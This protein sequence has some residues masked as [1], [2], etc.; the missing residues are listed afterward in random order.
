MPNQSLERVH[1]REFG[2]SMIV[3]TCVSEENLSNSLRNDIVDFHG[4]RDFP[5]IHN[6]P[7]L[8]IHLE[9]RAFLGGVQHEHLAVLVM[10]HDLRQMSFSIH[11]TLHVLF[12]ERTAFHPC[13]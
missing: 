5:F 12:L 13:R 1:L 9:D 4:I 10:Q 6:F 11:V 3:S 2:P 7:I 8:Q